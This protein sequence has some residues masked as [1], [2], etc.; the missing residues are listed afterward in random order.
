MQPL[1]S[2]FTIGDAGRLKHTPGDEDPEFLADGLQHVPDRAVIDHDND[3]LTV[4]LWYG[5]T[6][7]SVTLV[8]R[9]DS[10]LGIAYVCEPAKVDNVEGHLTLMP[11]IG[12]H[13][14]LSTG[15]AIP[16]GEQ[17]FAWSVPGQ[18]G[19][20]EHNGWRLLLPAGV[21][22]EW[23]ALPHNPYKKGGESEIE[24]GRIVIVMPFTQERSKYEMVLQIL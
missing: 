21:R 20:V 1:W 11:K 4:C 12:D 16:L 18:A 15:D 17:P 2:N 6:E 5:E 13:L 7:A 3:R 19:F 22:I 24:D 23:P 14:R 10:E 8:D 9:G